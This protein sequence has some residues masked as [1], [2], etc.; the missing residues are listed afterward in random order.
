[1]ASFQLRSD[2]VEL[3]G[4]VRHA[5]LDPFEPL[6]FSGS[7]HIVVELQA[8]DP[9]LLAADG[10]TSPFNYLECVVT[11]V[12]PY[13]D[14]PKANQLLAELVGQKVRLAGSWGD[15]SEPGVATTTRI[16]PIAWILVDRGITP[17][18]EEHGFSQVVR[19]VD[20]FAFSDDT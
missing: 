16:M 10:G 19:D 8:G 17:L 11:P 13:R 2:A 7:W 3:Q 5:W 6:A 20:L 15:V 18:V 1:M 4:I 12:S 14:I 9:L